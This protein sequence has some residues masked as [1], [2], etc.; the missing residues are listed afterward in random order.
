MQTIS[1]NNNFKEK[2][3]EILYQKYRLIATTI[4][5]Q[6]F[7]ILDGG[8]S[9]DKIKLLNSLSNPEKYVTWGIIKEEDKAVINALEHCLGIESFL[10][11]NLNK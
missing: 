1:E 6:A 10:K 5:N 3:Y 4:K 7:N 2:A 9:E 11:N 8:G